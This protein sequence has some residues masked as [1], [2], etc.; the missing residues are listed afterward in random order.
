[1][2]IYIGIFWATLLPSTYRWRSANVQ[3][4]SNYSKTNFQKLCLDLHIKCGPNAKF[5][6]PGVTIFKNIKSPITQ[7]IWVFKKIPTKSLFL[8][9]KLQIFFRQYIVVVA[10]VWFSIKLFWS[11]TLMVGHFTHV[12]VNF[13]Y[14]NVLVVCV[15]LGPIVYNQR[16]SSSPSSSS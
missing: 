9:E 3:W 10:F 8:L 1:M 13:D 4:R 15:G 2:L 5:Q 14:K 7:S 12:D 16:T 6:I 11:F